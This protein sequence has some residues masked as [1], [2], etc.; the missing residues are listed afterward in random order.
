RE[1]RE[2]LGLDVADPGRPV[3]VKEHVFPMTR[4]DGQHDT[5]F[6]LEI[7]AFDP[8]PTFTDAELRVENLDDVR[9]WT[10]EEI[11]QA[12]RLYDAAA[13]DD[14]G[15][16]TFT[17]RRFGHLLTDLLRHGRPVEPLLLPAL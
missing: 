3:W 4:W 5:Y 2:E 15:Y 7:D 12:Q 10:Y 11:Q 14:T 13:T 6:W 9:W 16:V 8:S 17:P 1:L